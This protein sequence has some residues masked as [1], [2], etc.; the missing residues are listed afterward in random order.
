[1]T[2]GITLTAMASMLHYS[3]GFLSLVETGDRV[4]TADV[5]SAYE[6]VLGG[7]IL[8]GDNDM[9]RKEIRKTGILVIR[10]QKDIRELAAS[11]A[12]GDPGPLTS[13][14]TGHWTDVALA[15]RTDAGAAKNLRRWMTDGETSTLRT[16]ALSVIAKLPGRDNADLVIRVLENDPRVRVLCLASVVS[17]MM[18]YDWELSL[19]VAKD[20][21]TAPNPKRLAKA[22]LKE[23]V[24]PKDTESRWCGATLLRDL[25]PVL[26]KA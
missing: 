19:R 8:L 13:T 5:V 21:T 11:L 15:A 26:A 2:A 25:A 9:W 4:A 18:Q 20:A 22:M 12:G 7:P 17:R 16:N 10:G 23:A 1:M 6:R 24:N 14:A 3:K